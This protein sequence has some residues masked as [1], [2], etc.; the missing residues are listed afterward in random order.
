MYTELWSDE[1]GE[2]IVLENSVLEKQD[3]AVC[4]GL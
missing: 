3:M 4:A 1:K 2:G